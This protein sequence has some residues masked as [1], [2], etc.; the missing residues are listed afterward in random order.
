MRN[1]LLV[2]FSTLVLTSCASIQ[3]M[4][5][6]N[7]SSQQRSYSSIVEYLY[8]YERGEI[9]IEPKIPNLNVPLKIG[10]A[11][12]PETCRTFRRH[13]LNENLKSNLL[14]RVSHKFK[15]KNIIEKV[16]V[17]P[18]TYFK[19]KGSFNNLRYIK[20]EFDVDI[21]VLIS[22][23]QIQ[24]TDR[25][26]LSVIYHLT[27]FGKY[28]IKGD[29]NDTVTLLDVAVYDINSEELLF[30]SRGYSKIK[31]DVAS[32]FVSEELRI[33]SQKGFNNGINNMIV[34]L[35]YELIRFRDKI[36]K[37]EVAVNVRYRRGYSGGGSVNIYGLLAIF[38]LMSVVR[39]YKSRE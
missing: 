19:R 22:Y 37:K 36:Q 32:A 15:E 29:K 28:V 26:S 30:K 1:I 23:D 2:L 39:I 9:N 6:M 4:M 24:Y 5:G 27:V 25:T 14:Q 7:Y 12:V 8:P 33:N 34:N 35:D 38:I 18:S 17:I 10:V 3:S 16:E 21:I 11:F 31:S 13:D 20:K